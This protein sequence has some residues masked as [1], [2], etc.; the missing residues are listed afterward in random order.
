MATIEIITLTDSLDERIKNGVET[1]TFFH[2]V[3]GTKHEIE[4]SE[5]NRE[6][7]AAH[8]AKLDKYI[9]AS[10]EI[11][12]VKP[13]PVKAAPKGD[14]R[15]SAIRTWAQANGFVVGDRGRIR[16]EVVEAYDKAHTPTLTVSPDAQADEPVKLVEVS[17]EAPELE[18][19]TDG[20]VDESD[21]V[22]VE[23]P[24]DDEPTDAELALLEGT[25]LTA[26]MSAEEFANFLAENMSAD[27]T[28]SAD[29]VVKGTDSE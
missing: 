16:A 23:F 8:L 10:R 20:V 3:F 26:N 27:G 17:T 14:G 21:L 28:I 29:K 24:Q 15:I 9:D 22:D 11:V 13:E 12:E 19:A 2:P 5:K 7:F 6:H 4:L 1:V 18:D 25:D